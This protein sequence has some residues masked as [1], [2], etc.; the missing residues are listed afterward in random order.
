MMMTLTGQHKYDNPSQCPFNLDVV[1]VNIHV[2]N[3]A[4][5][6]VIKKK[7]LFLRPT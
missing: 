3:D 4:K 7:L 2:C 5:E 1:R 6:K